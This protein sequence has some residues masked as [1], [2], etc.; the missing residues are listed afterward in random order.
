MNGVD[1]PRQLV[2]LVPAFEEAER[3]GET[4]DALRAAAP[5]IESLGLALRI[6]VVDDGS[7]DKTGQLALEHG[8]AR[9]VRHRRNLG[10]GAAVRSGLRAARAEGA[11]FVLKMDADLQHDPLEIPAVLAPLLADEADL[12]YGDRTGGL[13]YRM[14]L[15]RRA[16][17]RV[18]TGLMRWLTGWPLRDSQ[19]GIFALNRDYLEVFRLPGDYNYTQQLL[20]DAF[21]KGMRFAHVPVHFRKRTTG[22]SFVSLRYPLKALPQIVR[23]LVGVRPMKVFA[24]IGLA[25]IGVALVVAAIELAEWM[26]GV[27]PKPIEHVNLTLGAGLFGLQT[28]FF[29]L[30]AQLIVEHRD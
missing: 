21:H 6:L 1:G 2:I 13:E 11:D 27:A 9:V 29:G 28:L 15:V 8:A 25:F 18:F 14:P 10:L 23:V 5:A 7:T 16:G 24:P 19:P 20:L 22:R 26:A 4:C 3:I 17:N 30:L 12:V